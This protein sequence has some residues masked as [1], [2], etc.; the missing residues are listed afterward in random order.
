MSS[1]G[2]HPMLFFQSVLSGVLVG[3]VYALIGIGLT[4]IFGVM[5]VINF[6]HGDLLMLGMYATWLIFTLTGVDPY[7]SLIVV[8]PLLFLW[9][10]FLQTTFLN[11][12]IG[13]LPQNQI[14]FT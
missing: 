5:R 13:T 14:L 3:G 4:M 12:I 10:A 6:A 2:V 11:P 8:A 1:P 9:G 7:L